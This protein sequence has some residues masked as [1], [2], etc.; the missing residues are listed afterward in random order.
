MA[1]AE[2]Y[3]DYQFPRVSNEAGHRSSFISVHPRSRRISSGVCPKVLTL[4]GISANSA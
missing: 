3:A 4:E 1:E 2:G